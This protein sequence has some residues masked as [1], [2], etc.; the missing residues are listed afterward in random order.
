MPKR[1]PC[2]SAACCH[3]PTMSRFGPMLTEFQRLVLASS[4][5]RSC[6]GAW[7]SCRSTS[8]RPSCRAPSAAPD[9]ILGLP[10]RDDV[11]E[12]ELR[13]MPVV[14]EVVLV[15][16]GCRPSRHVHRVELRRTSRPARHR[17]RPPTAQMPSLASRNH[18]G[19]WYCLSDSSSGWN[20]PS[21]MDD[22]PPGTAGAS[23]AGKGTAQIRFSAV[24]SVKVFRDISSSFR[25]LAG[26]VQHG[27]TL[28]RAWSERAYSTT[29]VEFS[30]SAARRL[31]VSHGGEYYT[32]MPRQPLTYVTPQGVLHVDS[33]RPQRQAVA[34]G[35]IRLSAL[36]HGHYPGYLLPPMALPGLSSVG[37]LDAPGRTGLGPRTASQRRHRDLPAGNRP[38]GVHG[39]RPR[40][41]PDRWRY[42]RSPALGNCI[43]SAI[44][45]LAWDDF[46]G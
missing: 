4:S 19:Q 35:K 43:A 14:L 26:V 38:H 27:G 32:F 28:P 6:R 40:I 10:E 24:R 17:L 15:V 9:P 30:M 36:T 7:R 29:M 33:N 2:F 34:E 18:S 8:P 41:S 16:P 13:G 39:R 37:Y 44:R 45:I 31:A 20:G 1:S 21:A 42:H 5:S 23:W 46:T 12:A 3:S 11:L 25:L 22:V